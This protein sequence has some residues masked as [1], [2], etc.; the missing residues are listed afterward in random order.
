MKHQPKYRKQNNHKQHLAFIRK[1]P[2]CKC[3]TEPSEAFQFEGDAE[4]ALPLCANCMSDKLHGYYTF[5]D[6]IKARELAHKLWLFSGDV[7]SC[8][9]AAMNSKG[10]FT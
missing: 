9:S 1:L 6:E 10:L 8:I 2:C 3:N 5:A 4:H 7:L